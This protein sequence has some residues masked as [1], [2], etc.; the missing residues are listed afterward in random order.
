[1]AV[2]RHH[3]PTIAQQLQDEG[4]SKPP[5]DPD[6]DQKARIMSDSSRK[7]KAHHERLRRTPDPNACANTTCTGLMPWNRSRNRSTRTSSYSLTE[8]SPRR[9]GGEAEAAAAEA[10]AADADEA[11]EVALRGWIHSTEAAS[12]YT[13]QRPR[14]LFETRLH[15]NRSEEPAHAGYATK[16]RRKIQEVLRREERRV[17]LQTE[18]PRRY[19]LRHLA[20]CIHAKQP[21]AS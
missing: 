3:D 13:R 17:N 14:A 5:A 7:L 2:L 19:R 16:Q 6:E 1:M 10:A 11:V 21:R 18:S 4:F 9:R 8:E 12:I 20:T 15:L